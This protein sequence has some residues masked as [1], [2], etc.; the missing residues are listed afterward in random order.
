MC[1][2]KLN[3]FKVKGTTYS[4]LITFLNKNTILWKK[5]CV[6]VIHTEVILTMSCISYMLPD[7]WYHPANQIIILSKFFC[8]TYWQ[9]LKMK[10]RRISTSYR[11]LCIT[12]WIQ[13]F[14]RS[15]E[16]PW[17]PALLVTQPPTN[18][19]HFDASDRAS[20]VLKKKYSLQAITQK[21]LLYIL[22]ILPAAKLNSEYVTLTVC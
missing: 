21:A 14:C 19:N 22:S 7:M 8:V 13:A 16:I 5:C 6:N 3:V 12:F 20:A 17:K 15:K 10:K 9:F 2:L 11:T 4:F 1:L 18:L